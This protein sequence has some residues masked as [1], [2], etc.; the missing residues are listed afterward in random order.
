[1]KCTFYASWPGICSN[2]VNCEKPAPGTSGAYPY[3]VPVGEQV[4]GIMNW[5]MTVKK[6]QTTINRPVKA[7][8]IGL[9]SGEKVS[10]KIKPAR[11]GMG[12]CFVR[13][14]VDPTMIIPAKVAFVVDTSFATTIGA[15]HATIGTIEH[16]MA[17]FSGLGIDNAIVEIDGPEVPAMDGSAAPFMALL[18]EAGLTH[19]RKSRKYMKILEPVSIAHEGKSIS[20]E[21]A[22]SF[23]VSF[24]ID[25][26]HRVISRQH[27]E[28]E[29]N[30]KSFVQKVGIARTFGFL[31]EVEFM[32][33]RGL[34]LG[35]SLDNAVVIDEDSVLNSEGLR[36][37]D[38]F[39]R[40]KIL[41]LIGDL[42]LLGMPLLGRVTAVK[43]GHAM[44]HSLAS[45]LL[46]KPE[47]WK[48]VEVEERHGTGHG[49]SVFTRDK[50][51]NY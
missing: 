8:G 23:S 15:S 39:V 12:I 20:I 49:S 3:Q 4:S 14:D 42:A 10:I 47:V 7:A 17:A 32:R 31:H 21:P 22:S 36:F 34:A 18:M 5:N 38:E 46:K 6:Q 30:R 40:H 50:V 19:L 44:H 41:D 37:S 11:A 25:F 27:Y 26:A 1:M 35:G 9:H 13:R 33:S 51:V 28:L 43:S 2:E 29:V 48:M 24:D 45:L 16:L